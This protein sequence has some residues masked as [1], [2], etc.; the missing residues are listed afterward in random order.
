MAI[1]AARFDAHIIMALITKF[2]LILMAIHAR[3]GQAH[4]VRFR[5]TGEIGSHS[6]ANDRL[7]PVG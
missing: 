3:P 7:L 2:S 1:P 5:V 6:L 4:G